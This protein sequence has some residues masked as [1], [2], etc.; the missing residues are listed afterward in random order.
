[1][2]TVASLRSRTP[3]QPGGRFRS[4]TRAMMLAV[5]LAGAGWAVDAVPVI[6]V[7][8]ATGV[9]AGA[10]L[11]STATATF[12][13]KFDKAVFPKY[14]ATG[15]LKTK[16]DVTAAAI[17]DLFTF[18]S[19]AAATATYSQLSG[20][21]LQVAVA[22]LVDGETASLTI[23]ADKWGTAS[24]AVLSP[25]T[26]NNGGVGPVTVTRYDSTKAPAGFVIATPDFTGFLNNLALSGTV[27]KAA[28]GADTGNNPNGSIISL[29]AVDSAAA[30]VAGL[31]GTATASG[32]DNA[33]AVWTYI[34]LTAPANG[35]YDF[36]AT[37]TDA[38]GNTVAAGGAT[39]LGKVFV[40]KE[41]TISE[42]KQVG[43]FIPFANAMSVGNVKPSFK[44]FAGIDETKILAAHDVLVTVDIFSTFSNDA[45]DNNDVKAI[46]T[47]TDTDITFGA[48]DAVSN[49][50]VAWSFDDT[51]YSAALAAGTYTIRVNT[52][53][54]LAANHATGVSLN[55]VDTIKTF[56]VQTA[57]ATKPT[58]VIQSIRPQHLATVRITAPALTNG[59]SADT[60]AIQMYTT[61]AD[62]T[63][64]VLVAG[65][66]TDSNGAVA[67]GNFDWVSD[68]PLVDGTYYFRATHTDTS[69]TVSDL[70][71]AIAAHVI[72]TPI[73]VLAITGVVAGTPGNGTVPGTTV[74]V[75][76]TNPDY[77]YILTDRRPIIK[78]S[79]AVA[80]TQLSG[81]GGAT[82][83]GTLTVWG[84]S[85]G[86]AGTLFDS[87]AAGGDDF[88]NDK[89]ILGTYVSTT[90]TWSPNEALTPGSYS[91]CAK[92]EDNYDVNGTNDTDTDGAGPYIARTKKTSD[93]SN[94]FNFRILSTVAK[95]EITL[96]KD[97]T[98]AT[99]LLTTSSATTLITPDNQVVLHGTGNAGATLRVFNNGAL[100][101]TKVIT[102][103]SDGSW[104]YSFKVGAG[105]GDATELIAG[106]NKLTVQQV[107][108]CGTASLVTTTSINITVDDH[109][110]AAPVVLLPASPTT[111]SNL[112]PTFSGTT[113][114]NASVYVKVG[115][116]ATNINAA[117]DDQ[118]VTA[119]ATGA[120]T[121]T[122]S[123]ANKLTT[124][125]NYDG[126]GAATSITF[127]AV[128]PAGIASPY[129]T[130]RLVNVLTP[131]LTIRL[132]PLA[133]GTAA[134]D[135]ALTVDTT[136]IPTAA[137]AYAAGALAIK[138]KK[139]GGTNGTI[140]TGDSI[141]I[142]GN[143][144]IV[145]LGANV[146]A[147]G[148]SSSI[149]LRTGLKAAI[150]KAAAVTVAINDN[151]NAPVSLLNANTEVCSLPSILLTATL[152]DGS[153][154]ALSSS[155]LATMFTKS[156]VSITN[157][158]VA[159]VTKGTGLPG[160]Q[161]TNVWTIAITPST[162]AGVLS[163]SIPAGAFSNSPG[164][165]ISVIDVGG[166]SY[167]SGTPTLRITGS[168]F[169]AS[170]TIT[171]AQA[172][173]AFG[174]DATIVNK[175]WGYTSAPTVTV[176]PAP[177]SGAKA[178]AGFTS[179]T[180]I[181][182]ASPVGA[183]QGS[184]YTAAP[185]VRI[186]TGEG[187]T[188]TAVIGTGASVGKITG[189][190]RTSGGLYYSQV[191]TVAISAP[192]GG[193]TNATAT[194]T[195]SG[196]LVSGFTMTNQ[197]TGYDVGEAVTVTITATGTG[198]TA[199]ANMTADKVTSFT[200]DNTNSAA[201]S[202][203][204]NVIITTGSGATAT[205]TV[206]DGTLVFNKASDSD[207]NANNATDD[208]IYSLNINRSAPTVTWKWSS[209]AA[210]STSQLRPV[211]K[212][213]GSTYA[214]SDTL[215][216]AF[217]V[218]Q[219]VDPATTTFK[220]RVSF[221]PPLEATLS[222]GPFN[223]TTTV[224]PDFTATGCYVSA[225]V[226]IAGGAAF[227]DFD[228]TVVRGAK[229]GPT[230]GLIMKAGLYNSDSTPVVKNLASAPFVA[231]LVSQTSVAPVIAS[232]LGS[233][234]PAKA[235]KVPSYPMTVTFP[236]AVR[237][238]DETNLTV[239]NG[240][241]T[242]FAGSGKAFTFTLTP[243][244]GQVT[245]Q[246]DNTATNKVYDVAG[247]EVADSNIFTRLVDSTQPT[248]LQVSSPV[249]KKMNTSATAASATAKLTVVSITVTNGGTLYTSVP[250]V[251]FG[252]ANGGTGA[253][254]TAVLTDGV[255]TSVT[256][257]NGGTGFTGVET[258]TIAAPG[259]GGVTATATASMG[260]GAITTVAAGAGFGTGP[261]VT[262]S[263][264]AGSGATVTST[265]D[266]NG[267]ISG[268]TVVPGSG[269]TSV[270]TLRI[271]DSI[272]PMDGSTV[273]QRFPVRV[274]FSEALT[275]FPSA[276]LVASATGLAAGTSISL[277]APKAI[278]DAA[279][280]NAKPVGPQPVTGTGGTVY[281]FDLVV[282]TALTSAT[283]HTVRLV[284]PSQGVSD[285]AVNSSQA[286]QVFTFTYNLV[287]GMPFEV[288]TTPIF[289]NG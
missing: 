15:M 248:I 175:G 284:V 109:I 238:F 245:V 159:S 167:Y 16:A 80:A 282:P 227:D 154:P 22:G 273:L 119:S 147:D 218:N 137:N 249:F 105:V 267:A 214:A 203:A 247:N 287:N 255:V 110:P 54:V 47:I 250:A 224:S 252:N 166:G 180:V 117:G 256:V 53:V 69:G 181:T 158:T 30:A 122:L 77:Q 164:K 27:T 182:I 274:T 135:G 192:V 94:V 68:S 266:V 160:G 157:G 17:Y 139:V 123:A 26:A 191:P 46:T 237:A 34:P 208:E 219:Q 152:T 183:L 33:D 265:V 149:N 226:A 67:G 201:Y 36:A 125:T 108:L 143:E 223:G 113:E 71:D 236:N 82:A 222:T 253:T 104:T 37:A 195:I 40:W 177:G 84:V 217:F 96:V 145:G 91:L 188:A 8:D 198:C 169:E 101:P 44:G 228:V 21:E 225:V 176:V 174:A 131:N 102:T 25:V 156:S 106:T 142:A 232:T 146:V 257:T 66:V 185:T 229:S 263:G 74:P 29:T 73:P 103:P 205:A 280:A 163:A 19:T 111:L 100:M 258:L 190:T 120:W 220:L 63:N 179:A 230:M 127:K 60:T 244:E 4:L 165:Y 202:A 78:V 144:Y 254:G 90:G 6:T 204:P 58:L 85:R 38:A 216:G 277:A 129:T 65:K 194:A 196:G 235:S 89:V 193:G 28:T 289:S 52:K 83:R 79:T 43:S 133:K 211:T 75:G 115:G 50:G 162:T 172:N 138:V 270:P 189:L 87:V 213:D 130:P 173:G 210:D 148:A 59:L 70:S 1:M 171:A 132:D 231:T 261:T 269:Y 72:S 178:T 170:A 86:T 260:V 128:S 140:L 233:L 241:I 288:K 3:A 259:G 207:T 10:K 13:V 155:V 124:A 134:A 209:Q 264:G 234:T 7:S 187:A 55:S 243:G 283:D 271:H 24:G 32:V 197:G 64:P 76:G 215:V 99:T 5:G 31:A 97:V 206:V 276:S 186:S 118:V 262:L 114:P 278:Y 136:G 242:K 168:G 20:S 61:D 112:Q 246:Y 9:L 45:N 14:L 150:V 285:T 49:R 11:T 184:G 221:S 35:Y 268:Y 281:E 272:R 51:K 153:T 199:T 212:A 251:T 18:S 2:S 88:D 62:G 42:V 48:E 23:V 107:D 81:Y 121:L 41:P 126:S 12:S 92:W 279:P 57:A 239:S 240:V 200:V 39:T 161:P 275:A 56:T 141:T 151:P 98:D 95:P 116:V 286:S 93:A